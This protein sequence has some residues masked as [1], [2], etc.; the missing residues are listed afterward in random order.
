MAPEISIV[1]PHLNQPELLGQ[2]LRSL[3]AQDFDMGRAEVIVVDNGSR[4]L[5]RAVVADY[6][7]VLLAEEATP[8]PGP[9][10]NRGVALARARLLAFTDADCRVARD[11]VPAILAR[12]RDPGLAILGGDIRIFAQDPGRPNLA[13]AYECVYA[14]PQHAY[15][16][17]QGFSVTANLATRREVYDA[18]GPFA[19]IEIAE[20]TDWG[21]RAARLGYRTLYAPEVV[22][23]HPARRSMAEL[24]A[25]WDRNVGHHFQA[26]AGGPAGRAKWT[27][28]ALALTASPLAEIPRLAATDRLG[29][30]RDRARAFRALAALRLYRA[31]R[32]LA[33]MLHRPT[34]TA[35]TQWNRQ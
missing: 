8:G 12:F 28:K 19:G 35:A 7:Q 9:A 20:D 25:K 32:M 26:F 22:V 13:E 18:V 16:T 11:W 3:Y 1:V 29:G 33:V 24:Y 14:F 2:F 17:R 34:R 30:P 5:P 31:R 23:H 27:L 21:Q 4:A 10:R 15:I 6:P